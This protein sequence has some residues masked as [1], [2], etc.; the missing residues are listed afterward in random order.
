MNK[1]GCSSAFTTATITAAPNPDPPE[2]TI[3]FTAGASSV[4][5][6]AFA[7]GFRSIR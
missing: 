3:I 7:Q 4:D 5:F 2:F 1:D 6:S